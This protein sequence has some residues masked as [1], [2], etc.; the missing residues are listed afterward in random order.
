MNE[1]LLVWYYSEA[2]VHRRQEQDNR[3]QGIK[4]ASISSRLAVDLQIVALRKLEGPSC[5][6]Y[7]MGNLRKVE[8]VTWANEI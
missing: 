3:W 5:P 8:A 2:V 1:Y 4:A 6:I 7:W